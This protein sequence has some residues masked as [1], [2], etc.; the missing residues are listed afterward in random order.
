MKEVDDSGRVGV[1]APSTKIAEWIYFF[2]DP[3]RCGLLPWSC[4]QAQ[5]SSNRVLRRNAFKN[6]RG[7]YVCMG[8]REQQPSSPVFGVFL[9]FLVCAMWAAIPFCFIWVCVTERTLP[10][11]KAPICLS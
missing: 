2:V 1:S 11:P 6:I 7:V 9:S 4:N 5:A 8:L 10:T 3:W